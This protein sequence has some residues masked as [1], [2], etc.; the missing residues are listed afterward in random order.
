MI[1]DLATDGAAANIPADIVIVGSGPVGLTLARA[2]ER[3]GV[4]V[5]V[6]EAGPRLPSGELLADSVVEQDGDILD[7]IAEARTR[8]VGGGLNLWGGQ[9]GLLEPFDFARTPVWPITYSEAYAGTAEALE[10]AGLSGT[11]VAAQLER[12]FT[13]HDDGAMEAH[14][15]RLVETAWLPRPKF[16]Q[17][18][19]NSLE[20]SR[21]CHL[22]Y[23]A[24]CV[25]IH[26]DGN[27]V[28]GVKV[29]TAGRQPFSI[30]T[31][32]VAL[33]AGTIENA[34][35]LLLPAPGEAT[36][37]WHDNPWL[38]RGFNEHMDASVGLLQ[39]H[40]SDKLAQLFDPY[41]RN[42]IKFTPKIAWRDRGKTRTPL[43]VC[44][45]LAY[46][47]T[48]GQCMNDVGLL[49]NN[50]LRHPSVGSVRHFPRAIFASAR[51]MAPL[52]ARY[53]AHRRIGRPGDGEVALRV[54][55]E[56]PA[57]RG[58]A[59]RLSRRE[60]DR[61]GVARCVLTWE[62]GDDELDAMAEF[63]KSVDNWLQDAGIGCILIKPSLAERS[64]DFWHHVNAGLH[65]AGTTRMGTDEQ[66]GVVDQQ[67]RVHGTHGLYVCGASVFPTSGYINPTL[68]AMALSVRLA[69][70]IAQAR[71]SLLHV[72]V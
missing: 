16:A 29:A 64:A 3:R 17:K 55:A 12:C 4:T 36:Q 66:D 9:L 30:K 60:V 11:L 35:L 1:C 34:R 50:L 41:V 42:G 5:V 57:R 48:A 19:W 53:I 22:L 10:I 37:P 38:G 67:L 61:M 25:G 70:H 26:S 21:K 23:N 2:L 31:L 63:S 18:F 39:V 71:R 8:Q 44:G 43:G 59:I 6:L 69:D 51:R 68:T 47:L 33:A 49:L 65:H 20:R 32:G 40:N 14:N 58:S 28:T 45:M 56:Q 52:V 62:R 72:A 46:S 54:S 24:S 7:C 13:Y 27:R 15:L